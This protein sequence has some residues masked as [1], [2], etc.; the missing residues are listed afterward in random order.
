M[1]PSSKD[2]PAIQDKEV[3]VPLDPAAPQRIYLVEQCKAAF[4]ALHFKVGG[5]L[6]RTSA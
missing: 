4:L 5:A 3:V 6:A 2:K 1:E